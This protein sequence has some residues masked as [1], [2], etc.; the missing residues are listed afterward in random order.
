[1]ITEPSF[2]LLDEPTGNLDTVTAKEIMELIYGV[3]NEIG[4]TVILVTHDNEISSIAKRK[5]RLV[6]GRIVSNE[7]E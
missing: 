4:V 3:N 5:I 7:V 2:L 1:M 6:D